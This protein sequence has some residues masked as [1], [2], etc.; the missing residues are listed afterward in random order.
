MKRIY[1]Y[2]FTIEAPTTVVLK[3]GAEVLKAGVQNG[4]PVMWA[5]VDPAAADETW[6]FDVYATGGEI[7]D[8]VDSV[9]YVDTIFLDNGLVF[10]IFVA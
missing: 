2:P 4:N 1:K 9:S 8:A 7:D 3:V 6:T 5:L 10:H